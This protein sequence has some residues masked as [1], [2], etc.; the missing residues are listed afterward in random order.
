LSIPV[1]SQWHAVGGSVERARET[2]GQVPIPSQPGIHDEFLE[3]LAHELRSP[4]DAIRWL[5]EAAQSADDLSVDDLRRVMES[6]LRSVGYMESLLDTMLAEADAS[7]AEV[8]LRP[9]PVKADAVARETVE[10]LAGPLHGRLV[11]V[12]VEGRTMVL[13]DPDRLRQAL[14]ALLVNAAR[15]SP[16]GTPISVQVIERPHEV[17]VA[18][19]DHCGGVP[20]GARERIFDRHSRLDHAGEGRG[21]GLF[22]ARRL[23]RAH[24]GDLRVASSTRGCRFAITLPQAVSDRSA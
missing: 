20:A 8:R 15:Y 10:D 4:I 22:V 13:A 19:A 23:A 6:L 5:A 1:E 3:I 17:E 7:S 11:A 14:S 16:A 12:S 21:L 9:R 2:R 18:V 24:G